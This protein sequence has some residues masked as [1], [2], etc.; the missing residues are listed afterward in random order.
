MLSKNGK[1]VTRRDF[2]RSAV[3]G[4]GLVA[5]GSLIQAC[6][7]APAAAPTQAPAAAE[8]TKAPAAEPTK[9]AAAE[10]TKAPAAEP[11]QALAPEP[12]KAPEVAPPAKEGGVTITIMGDGLS[13]TAHLG[14]FK[15]KT[16]KWEEATGHKVKFIDIPFDQL[17]DKYHTTVASGTVDYDLMFEPATWE[18]DAFSKGLAVELPAEIMTKDLEW[19]DVMSPYKEVLHVWK[20]KVM[21]VPCDGDDHQLSY[22][23][24]AFENPDIQAKYKSKYGVDLAVPKDHDEMLQ[25]AE[26]FQGWDW[27]GR[28]KENY[29]IIETM[30]RSGGWS[31]YFFLS[32][33][34]QFTK[35]PDDNS[36]FFDFGTMKPRINNPGF[37][38]A[39]EYMVKFSKLGP[40]GMANF[41]T[42]DTYGLFI[43]GNGAME[44]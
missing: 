23:A 42:A 6:A 4:L 7:Q 32:R 38:R 31:T 19:D 3:A 27:D 5:G 2:L 26:F 15:E 18:G 34:A 11:T 39:L 44:N 30:G 13:G 21:A 25:I 41:T 22:R 36:M 24:D 37:V 20:G 17:F 35:H 9:A 12:T 1:L 16:P 28:G 29:G 10:P 33:A 43:G 40:P 14:A 8:P